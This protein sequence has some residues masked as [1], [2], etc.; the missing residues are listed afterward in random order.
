MKNLHP[1]N[2]PPKTTKNKAIER[3]KESHMEQP[4]LSQVDFAADHDII[5]IGETS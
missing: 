4:R 3:E 5:L 2:R 1:R